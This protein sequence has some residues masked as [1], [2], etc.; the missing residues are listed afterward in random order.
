MQQK[1]IRLVT[2]LFYHIYEKKN[3]NPKQEFG[4]VD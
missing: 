3:Q 2:K 4:G 1:Q